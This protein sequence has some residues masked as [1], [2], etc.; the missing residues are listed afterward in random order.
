HAA[1]MVTA[2][3]YMVVRSNV[4][5]RL[6]PTAM[7]VVATVGAITA[8][9]AATIGIAQNDIK[10]VLAYSTVSQLGFMFLAAGVGAF[11]AAIFHVMT[12]AFFKACL[13]LGAGSVIHGCGGEQDMRKM[14]GLRKYMPW[15]HRTMAVA[16]YAIAGLPLAAGFFS[17]D[18]ILGGAWGYSRMIWL[19][20][21]IAAAFTAFYMFR[22]YFMTFR[23]TFRGMTGE[24]IEQSEPEHAGHNLIP[25]RRHLDEGDADLDKAHGHH[26][27]HGHLPHESPASMTG[28]LAILAILSVIGG[29]I[30]IPAAL[31]G[32]HPTW[33]Q[34]WL[35]PVLLP[36]NGQAF[37]FHEAPIAQELGLMLAS[38]AI[39][40]FGFWLARALYLKRPAV[41][42][43]VEAKLG[44]VYPILSNKY[45]VDEFYNATVVRGTLVFSTF[46]SWFDAHVIDGLVNLTRNITVIGFGEGSNLIDKYIV[47]GAVNGVAHAAKSGSALLRRMQSGVV[48]NYALVMGGGVVLL[49]MVYLFLKP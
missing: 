37:H 9:F 38:V 43:V 19:V 4:L 1:T 18:E 33:F 3:V 35:E 36:V 16:T 23:G 2:G 39:A 47:D 34:R 17:K 49:A 27:E 25:D 41:P 40:F 15:T 22:L 31:G 6:S 29:F 26:Q 13:F 42:D 11:T 28:V 48:E 24:G 7:G 8:I 14:G 32:P 10:K 44:P 5:F 12:H 21:M 20:G 45:F 46:L 30:G